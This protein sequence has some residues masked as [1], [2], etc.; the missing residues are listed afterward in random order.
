MPQAERVASKTTSK[1]SRQAEPSSRRRGRHTT[2]GTES[3]PQTATKMP[4]V[5]G[6]GLRDALYTLEKCGLEVSFRGAG[7]VVEQSIPAGHDIA[8]GDQVEIELKIEN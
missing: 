2:S 3:E 4:S 5:I 8:Q 1:L 6:M 7:S